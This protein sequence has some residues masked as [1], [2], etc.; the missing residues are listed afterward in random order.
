MLRQYKVYNISGRTISFSSYPGTVHSGD[1]W[2]MLSNGLTVQETTNDNYNPSS[3]VYVVNESVPEFIRVMVA[4][5]LATSTE[6]WSRLFCTHNSGTYNNQYMIIDMK[7][8]EPSSNSTEGRLPNGTFYVLEQMANMCVFADKSQHLREHGYWASYNI[9]SFPEVYAYSGTK[10]MEEEY[11]TYFSYTKY[12]RAEIFRRNETDVRSL[13]DVKRLMRYNNYL[14]DPYSLIPNCSGTPNNTCNPPY[15]ASLAIASRFDVNVRGS[16]N[17][18]GPLYN[19]LDLDWFG[20]I[21]NKIVSWKEHSMMKGHLIN[22]PTVLPENGLPPFR[23][24]TSPFTTIVH[25]GI[26][27]LLNFTY[28]NS[29]VLLGL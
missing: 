4:N 21:D 7:R 6:E 3:Y 25:E 26:P 19:Y 10:K 1:D 9:P 20:A 15:S 23:W 29:E 8:Y 27:D 11:G 28:V 14:H 22:G 2:Y 13:E 18:Q 24:S 12:S 5:T 16:P 17:V